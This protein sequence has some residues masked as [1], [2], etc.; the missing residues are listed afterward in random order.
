M[1]KLEMRGSDVIMEPQNTAIIIFIIGTA[2]FTTLFIATSSTETPLPMT[3]FLGME[4]LISIISILLWYYTPRQGIITPTHVTIK[5]PFKTIT[6]SL[7]NVKKI[8]VSHM[9]G[10]PS[11]SLE[12]A[13]MEGITSLLEQKNP[14][15]GVK[16]ELWMNKKHTFMIGPFRLSKVEELKT[17]LD[18]LLPVQPKLEKQGFPNATLA[19]TWDMSKKKKGNL[20]G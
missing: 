4:A 19:F 20:K 5:Y 11:D 12:Q 16:I 17:Y 9:Y 14:K 2:V 13:I 10:K 1:S 6:Q 3:V 8:K 18:S 15:G 7:S